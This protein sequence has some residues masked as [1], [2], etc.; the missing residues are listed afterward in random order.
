MLLQ[1]KELL[2][3]SL[4]IEENEFLHAFLTLCDLVTLIRVS[5]DSEHF[6]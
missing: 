4:D 5:S 3:C 6:V 1:S 2:D